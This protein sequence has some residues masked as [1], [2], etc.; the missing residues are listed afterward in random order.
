MKDNYKKRLS[1]VL[2]ACVMSL[3]L[4]PALFL[5]AACV[6][7]DEPNDDDDED[8][9]V[10]E[11]PVFDSD[12]RL[13]DDGVEITL[14]V[15]EDEEYY[16]IYVSDSAYGE[17]VLTETDYGGETYTG[18]EIMAYYRVEGKRGGRVVSTATYSYEKELF[19]ENTIIFSPEDDP[20]QVQAV[21]D[22]IYELQRGSNNGQFT[23]RR[24][25]LLFKPGEYS[26]TV[27]EGYYTSVAG[28][29]FA[30]TDTY[31]RRFHVYADIASN[32]NA[33]CNFWRSVEN[34]EISSSSVQWA[35]SQATSMRRVKING[36]LTLHQSGGWSSGGFLADSLVAGTVGSGSQQQWLSRNDEWGR[37]DGNNFNMVYVGVDG[38]IPSGSWPAQALTEVATTPVIREKAFLVYDEAQGYGVFVPDLRRDS[39]GISWT[40]NG[41][42]GTL[43]PL[44]EFYIARADRDDADT[45]NSALAAGKNLILSPGIYELDKPIQVDRENTVVLGLGY[46]TLRITDENRDTL[47]RIADVG[48]I[49]MSGILFDA[50]TH[51]ETLLEVGEEGA[52]KDHSTN[53]I[54]LSDLFFRVGGHSDEPTYAHT[55]V[56]VNSSDVIGD[57]FWVWR[58]DHS[59][60]VGWD[61]NVT[62]N[63]LVVNGDNVTFYGLFV[64]H[65]HEYQTLWN[66]ENGSTY[67]Y[68]SEIPY[69]PPEQSAYMSH[70]G[71]V[72]GYASYKVADHV[73]THTAYGLGI[74]S[75]PHNPDIKVANAIEAPANAGIYIEHAVTVLLDSNPC[76]QSVLNGHGNKLN[77]MKSQINIYDGGVFR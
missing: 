35:V 72:N 6:N 18:D 25:A 66:G 17:Y 33:T 9:I 16:D 8:E 24:Y 26:S 67:F 58:A 53:P 5:L 62:V 42:D 14:P 3:T 55:S 21:I 49:K 61:V 76:L 52:S 29:G 37:W 27:Y 69:D 65:Y 28:L 22:E 54:C 73:Q 13:T 68:Q 74:Y 40:E 36:N 31:I 12:V 43:M 41:S 23:D 50:G 44:D 34:I 60:G 64:E 46:A 32:N 19:G 57:N 77:S 71:T 30:P 47:M 1:A 7:T 4:C 70:D 51:S 15:D 59:Y 20:D 63:G 75:C 45:I 10:A 11:V 48:G 38:A 56:V 39:V 2:V